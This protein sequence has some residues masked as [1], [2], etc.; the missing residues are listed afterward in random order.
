[1]SETETTPAIEG[2]QHG[3][4][5]YLV[6]LLPHPCG[7]Y[8]DIGANDH[9]DCSNTLLFH[10]RGWRGLLIEPNPAYWPR[11]LSF[12]PTDFLCPL[13]ASNVDGIADM[14]VCRGMTSL[15]PDWPIEP[16]QVVPV[17]TMTLANILKRWSG[18]DWRGTDFCSID[19]EGMEK[20][21][22]EGI[23]FTT[24]RPKVFCIEWC[25]PAG[26]D[27]SDWLP[28]LTAQGYEVHWKGSLNMILR[29]TI[30]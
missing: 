5:S 28:M 30:K 1:M 10:N 22:I 9:S 16:E 4:D 11:L 3:E 17:R 12:R 18:F 7:L 2:S 25:D 19:V 26:K 29:S 6:G 24:F 15:Q 14:R 13:A 23:D 21:V 20:A 27:T 8:V